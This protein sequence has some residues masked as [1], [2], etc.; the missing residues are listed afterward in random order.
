MHIAGP[1]RNDWSSGAETGT[2]R[3]EKVVLI[4][5]GHFCLNQKCQVYNLK[6]IKPAHGLRSTRKT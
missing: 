4:A 1:E 5:K 6:C 2:A 3:R